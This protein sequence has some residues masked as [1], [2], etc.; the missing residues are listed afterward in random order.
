MTTPQENHISAVSSNSKSADPD[1]PTT[2]NEVVSKP[3]NT[4]MN[5]KNSTKK[6]VTNEDDDGN[7]SSDTEQNPSSNEPN[8]S[9]KSTEK[10]II[11]NYKKLWSHVAKGMERG[12]GFFSFLTFL[13][14]NQ[15]EV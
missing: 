12:K 5:E 9:P 14:N 1:K 8:K 13:F 7:I 4:E 15:K 11:Y 10:N 6:Q 3:S 2:T